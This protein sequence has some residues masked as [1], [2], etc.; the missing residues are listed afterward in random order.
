MRNWKIEKKKN[1][2]I[3]IK[4]FSVLE[5]FVFLTSYKNIVR[6]NST[7]FFILSYREEIKYLKF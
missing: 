2:Y 1:N 5:H 7:N 6:R 3:F 4:L